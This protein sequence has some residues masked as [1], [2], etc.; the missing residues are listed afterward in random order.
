MLEQYIQA[1]K[2]LSKHRGEF[3]ERNGARLPFTQ[4]LDL[5]L[6]QDF[7]LKVGA[8][9]YQLQLTYDIYNFTNLLNREWGET[10]FL[11]NDNY[12][13]IQFA[14]F[15]SATNLTPQYRFTPQTS[16]PFSLS[17]STA[18]GISARWISQLGVRV[19]F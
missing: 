14:G 18:P 10:Y 11:S 8:R 7:N 1:D 19:N 3:S 13:L 4:I 12:R 6:A 5:K 9:T 2:Y 17:S 15:V 16:T